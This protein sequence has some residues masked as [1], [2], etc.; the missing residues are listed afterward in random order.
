[1]ILQTT[2]IKNLT[3]QNKDMKIRYIIFLL[4]GILTSSFKSA[5]QIETNNLSALVIKLTYDSYGMT[6]FGGSLKVRNLET[7]EVFESK[8]RIGFNPFVIIENLPL[9]NY[10]VE[11]LKINS[12]SN[13]L[14]SRN[15]LEFNQLKLD[16]SKVYY[17]GSYL[18]EKI[19]PMMELNFQITRTENDETKKIYKQLK[20]KSENWLKLQIDFEQR[21]LINDSTTI[22]IKNYR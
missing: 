19:P 2:E 21:L 1:M 3:I 10:K 5:D 12:G 20:K 17:L 16:T 8:S 13:V 6:G 7:N 9:G 15:D 22:K 11:E 18:T 4:I 14:T